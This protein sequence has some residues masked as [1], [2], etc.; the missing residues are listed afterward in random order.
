MQVNKFFPDYKSINSCNEKE[1]RRPC[2]S[3]MDYK[4]TVMINFSGNI[5]FIVNI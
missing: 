1:W 2:G 5:C 4:V 3:G